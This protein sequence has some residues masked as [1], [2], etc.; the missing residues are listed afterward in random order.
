MTQVGQ[1]GDAMIYSAAFT[2]ER[3]GSLAVGV[4]VRPDRPNQIRPIDP[5]VLIRWA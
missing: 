1:D 5:W 2:P 4:R 3:S